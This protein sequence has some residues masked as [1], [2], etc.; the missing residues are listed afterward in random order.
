MIVL[1]QVVVK[2]KPPINNWKNIG[3]TTIL[4]GEAD[5]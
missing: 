3:K 1:S 5:L 4:E 2:E